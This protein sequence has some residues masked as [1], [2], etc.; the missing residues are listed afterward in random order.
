MNNT[1][2]HTK[3]FLLVLLALVSAGVLVSVD[4]VTATHNGVCWFLA[5]NMTAPPTRVVTGQKFTLRH[6]HSSDIGLSGWYSSWTG[7][8]HLIATNPDYA[9]TPVYNARPNPQ[10]PTNNP[11]PAC[12]TES[13]TP[14]ND[15]CAWG[16]ICFE[17]PGSATVTMNAYLFGHLY[18]TCS[19]TITATQGAD[20]CLPDTTP[21]DV[22]PNIQGAQLTVPV[23][24]TIDGVGNCVLISPSCDKSHSTGGAGPDG[25][26]I[27]ENGGTHEVFAYGVQNAAVVKFPTWSA[28]TDVNGN[29][30]DDIVWYQGTNLGGG[31]WRAIINHANHPGIGQ[32]F[33]D[34]WMWPSSG[35]SGGVF[36][37]GAHFSRANAIGDIEIKRVDQTLNFMPG[38]QAWVDARPAKSENSAFFLNFL[39]DA[40]YSAKA[41]NLRGYDVLADTCLYRKGSAPCPVDWVGASVPSCNTNR[42]LIDVEVEKDMVTK[43]VFRYTPS[44]V[45]PPPAP[46]AGPTPPP[47]GNPPPPGGVPP[48]P[49][50]PVPPPPSG[51]PTPPPSG[52]PPSPPGSGS[53]HIKR[54]NV[55]GDSAALDLRFTTHAWLG[56]N[57]G[58][59]RT[60]NPAQFNGVSPNDTPTQAYVTDFPGYT[61]RARSC[62]YAVGSS[63]CIINPS[64]LSSPS[65]PSQDVM[66]CNGSS[67]FLSNILVANNTIRKVVAMYIPECSDGL[68]NDG[69]GEIDATDPGCHEDDDPNN[70]YDPDDTSE[71]SDGGGNGGSFEIYHNPKNE[72]TTP[73]PHF[74]SDIRMGTAAFS[75]GTTL[76]V[77]SISGFSG[78]VRIRVVGIEPDEAPADGRGDGVD[79]EF[80]LDDFFY[81]YDSERLSEKT[82]TISPS[83]SAAVEFKVQK[84]GIVPGR[85]IVRLQATSGSIVKNNEILVVVGETTPG[86]EE[87]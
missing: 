42:C 24:M 13:S 28:A 78:N 83:N 19:H 36:C 50:G 48:P 23:G 71:D 79:P 51:G 67:C 45:S 10:G 29:N 41:T 4:P 40:T 81:V 35:S 53:V 20:S 16:N 75:T 44:S 37:D 54:V 65:N 17:Q 60:V 38:T 61:E 66:T 12:P 72:L 68:D 57:Q 80:S 27:Y 33:T 46:P 1:S 14:P 87:R 2:G 74:F 32:I 64:V 21:T 56:I 7:A 63:E 11:E 3:L 9:G 70:P 43:V 6:R 58:D 15:H 8:Q 82:V 49:S 18:A 31:T 76:N 52:G 62:S 84:R 39:A 22:C 47:G 26:V 34:A 59:K 30:Q 55:D 73:H 77:R 5:G 69:D 86:F 25:L 85:Y